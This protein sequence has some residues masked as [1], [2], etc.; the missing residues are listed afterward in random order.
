MC[1][2]SSTLLNERLQR[3]QLAT[4]CSQQARKMSARSRSV[5]I[6][7]YERSRR[8]R[9]QHAFPP[10]N[11]DCRGAARPGGELGLGGKL[12]DLM[13]VPKMLTESVGGSR[14]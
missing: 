6:E 13:A 12:K 2:A 7:K 1:P 5:S 8:R 10:E 3:A 11:Y 4:G 9:R 14:A